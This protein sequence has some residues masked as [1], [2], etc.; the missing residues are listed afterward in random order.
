MKEEKVLKNQHNINKNALHKEYE[1]DFHS[2]SC[3][4]KD[5]EEF[6]ERNLSN[7]PSNLTVKGRVKSF[8]SFFSKSLR[9]LQEKKITSKE[10]LI[11]DV[12]GIRIICPFIEDTNSAEKIVS[13]IFQIVEIERKGSNYTFKEFGYESTH[14]LFKIPPFIGDKYQKADGQTF[15][16]DIAEVQ[17]RTILQDAWA[18]VEHELVYKAEFRPFDAPM[19]RKLASINAS[20]TLADTIFQ[21]I[22]QYQR[23]LNGELE[24]RHESFFSKLEDSTD[25]FIFNDEPK[26]DEHKE[27]K[28]VKPREVNQSSIDDLLLNALFS[29]NRNDFDDA[30]N[31]YSTILKLNP[32]EKTQA[33]IYKHRGMAYFAK[34]LYNDALQD[35]SKALKIDKESDKPAYYTG[36]VNLVLKDYSDA[37]E[38]LSRAIEINQYHAFYFYRRAEAYFHIDD[39]PASLADCE[40]AM[41]LNE[42]IEGVIKLKQILLSKLKM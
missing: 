25:N 7:L 37:I 20:L 36:L 41:A 12:I 8:T 21:E 26:N 22:R 11:P 15:T 17:I 39:F 35:F 33:I 5:L 23:Q 13:E 18:E 34:S 30:I 14:M 9:Y 38:N 6:L 4:V 24:R 42:S 29:H 31:Y 3:I 27:K 2:R 32:N 28:A 10:L 16:G 40:S 19:K 1:A